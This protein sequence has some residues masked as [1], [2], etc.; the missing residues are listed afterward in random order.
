MDTDALMHDLIVDRLK[1]KFASQ[2]KEIT[3]NA[4]NPDMSLGNHGMTVACVQVETERS[5]TS[6]QAAKWK[7]MIA[8]CPRLILMVPKQSKVKVMELLWSQGIA[9]RVGVGSYEILITMP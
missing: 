1:A 9:G 4:G 3:V 8:D 6:E 2:Y 7:E 5:I